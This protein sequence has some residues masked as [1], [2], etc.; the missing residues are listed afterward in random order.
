MKLDL[1]D[2]LCHTLFGLL[3]RCSPSRKSPSRLSAGTGMGPDEMLHI[4]SHL[5]MMNHFA[6][7]DD[8]WDLPLQSAIR[9][10]HLPYLMTCL[11]A[12]IFG[13]GVAGMLAGNMIFFFAWLVL[14]YLIGRRLFD[15]WTALAA[16]GVLSAMP[17]TM[18]LTNHL[19]NDIHVASSQR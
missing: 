1:D 4:S 7:D 8:L 13:K 6:L 3:W 12:G 14:V 9:K 18:L 19:G 17:L 15:P 16:S 5:A 11:F 2:R 10:P